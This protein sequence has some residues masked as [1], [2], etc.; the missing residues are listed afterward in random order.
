MATARD[1]IRGAM[2]LLGAIASGETP[3]ADEQ[4]DALDAFNQMLGSW[5]NEG[6]LIQSKVRETFILIPG[7]ASYTIGDT[8]D[9]VTTRPVA[10][11]AAAILNTGTTNFETQIE[12]ITFE[13][14]QNITTKDLSTSIP[15]KLYASGT[16]PNETITLWPVPSVAKTLV[17][18]SQKPFATITNLSTTLDYQPGIIRAMR[19]NLAMELASE[20]GK[21]ASP[22]IVAIATES[23]E[24][25]K[26]QN[27]KPQF[28]ETDLGFLSGRIGS[29]DYRT[30][31]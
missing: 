24:Y 23:K 15:Q 13:Q 14:F 9:F 22:E 4:S 20:F 12:V 31:E 25:I 10:I 27:I 28:M 26:R 16:A 18:Y 2:R 5:S 29:F 3:S 7:Q 6:L 11:D 1:V 17:L 8:G 30:G 19:F 21:S